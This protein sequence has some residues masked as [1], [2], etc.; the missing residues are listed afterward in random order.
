MDRQWKSGAAGAPPA[1]D[2]AS[3][4]YPTAGNPGGGVP[5]TKPGPHWYHMVTEELL[6]LIASA[7]IAF[8]KTNVT[9]VRAA[10]QAMFGDKSVING[11][12]VITENAGAHTWTVAVKTLAG[13]D[14]SLTNPVYVAFRDV[15]PASSARLIRTITGALSLVIPSTATLGHGS[16]RQQHLFVYFIDNAGAVELAVSNLPPDY[17]GF[18]DFRLV[19]TVA[20]AGG[21]N[22]PTTVYAAAIR[23][24]IPWVAAAKVQSTQAVA[25]TWDAAASQIDMFPVRMPAQAFSAYLNANQSI[26]NA[27]NTKVVVDTEEFDSDN[28]FDG[29]GRFQPKLAGRYVV[30]WMGKIQSLPDQSEYFFGIFKNGAEWKRGHQQ[31]SGASTEGTGGSCVV[32]MN[33]CNDYLELFCWQ[34][35]AGSRNAQGGSPLTYFSAHRIGASS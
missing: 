22:S 12:I 20:I 29:A 17:P 8:D 2:N 18:A 30:T 1:L 19:N 14:P 24:N 31:S 28:A 25:G 16:A 5:A 6:A 13:N 11:K 33:G 26:S 27:T 4:G 34:S 7:D 9:Q 32:N 21:S 35:S 10:L 15:A 3:A 23:N